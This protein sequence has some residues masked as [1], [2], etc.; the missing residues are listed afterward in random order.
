M[1]REIKA[2][3][4]EEAKMAKECKD[5][6]KKDQKQACMILAKE[7][8]RARK[9]KEGMYKSRAVMNNMSMQL[10]ANLALTKAAGCMQKSA[11]VMG[12]MNDM[13]KIGEMSKEMHA[14]AREMEKAG[15][16][17]E[18]MNEGIEAMDGDDI[19]DEAN[20]QVEKVVEE[21]TAGMFEGADVSNVPTAAPAAPAAAAAEEAPAASNGAAAEQTDEAEVNALR[22]RLQAL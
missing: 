4:R 6:A 5:L 9:A 20:M 7:I 8:V 3:E 12:A 10:A 16:I 11:E 22:D 14:M 18:M 13:M 2:L 15:M 1:D 21:L 17:E 19:E